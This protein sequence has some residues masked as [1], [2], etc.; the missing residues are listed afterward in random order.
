VEE[1][2]YNEEE[3]EDDVSNDYPRLP[4]RPVRSAQSTTKKAKVAPAVK[5]RA[6][7]PVASLVHEPQEEGE[8]DEGQWVV[9]AED[10]EGQAEEFI[11][12]AGPFTA[13]DPT[14]PAPPVESSSPELVH[15]TD[16]AL[17]DA[18][19]GDPNEGESAV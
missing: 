3:Y 19:E 2:E 15:G 16:E 17:A 9:D 11:D 8:A 14:L 4:A 7:A 1:Q 10:G 18:Q 6:R 5:P 12:F 13:E